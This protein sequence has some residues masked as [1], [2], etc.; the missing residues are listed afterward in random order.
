MKLLLHHAQVTKCLKIVRDHCRVHSERY[1]LVAWVRGHADDVVH[2]APAKNI[3]SLVRHELIWEKWHGC[4]RW[5]Q[6]TELTNGVSKSTWP[7][8]YTFA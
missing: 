1:C 7:R 3:V 4:L 6:G 2:V 8:P 5:I